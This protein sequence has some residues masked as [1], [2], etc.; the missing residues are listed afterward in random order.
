MQKRRSRLRV[1]ITTVSAVFAV[2]LFLTGNGLSQ[3]CILARSSVSILG[4]SCPDMVRTSSIGDG[5]YLPPGDWQISVGYRWQYSFR[6][7]IGTE[8]QVERRRLGTVSENRIHLFDIGVSYGLNHRLSLSASIPFVFASRT[9][10]GNVDRLMGIP[11]APD[12]VFKSVG[13]GDVSLSA[14]TWLAR[15]PAENRQNVS[16]GF[17]VKL[18]TGKKN[19]SD[20]VNT[21]NG[22]V[23]K[24][25]DPSIQ[26]GDGGIGFTI[27]V[28][29]FK[30]FKHFTLSGSA[31]YLFNPRNTNGVPALYRTRLSEAVLS[32]ADQYLARVGVSVPVRRV[33]GMAIYFGGR[34]EGVPAHD[35]FGKSDGFRRPGNATSIDPGFFY[36]RKRETW[37]LSIP[38]VVRRERTRSV[39][40]SRENFQDAA[41]FADVLVL[42]GYSRRF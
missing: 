16:I 4:A 28:L 25:V 12:Q 20:W 33:K 24:I 39:P 34:L 17:G 13:F 36:S 41:A 8:E 9:R 6:P 27:D 15:P 2:Q 40:E 5:G 26:L 21:P 30:T 11:N 29:A 42:V 7:Y 38:I 32:V 22:R 37:S 19:V 14:R 23:K 10:P 35:V 31:V 1:W 18:P 3:G